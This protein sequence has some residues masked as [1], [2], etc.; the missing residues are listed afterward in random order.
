M[1]ALTGL[2]LTLLLEG[3]LPE[4]LLTLLRE[5]LTGLR[6]TLLTTLIGLLLTDFRDNFLDDVL[7]GVLLRLL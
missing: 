1:G 7:A 3:A 5:D 6:L 4:L 2:L